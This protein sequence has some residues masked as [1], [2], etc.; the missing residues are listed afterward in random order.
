VDAC[1]VEWDVADLPG[2]TDLPAGV[3]TGNRRQFAMFAVSPGEVAGNTRGVGLFSQVLLQA[4]KEETSGAWPPA[5]G[6]IISRV[7]KLLSVLRNAGRAYQ[8]PVYLWHRDAAGNEESEPNKKTGAH[9]PEGLYQRLLRDFIPLAERTQRERLR[10]GAIW[11]RLAVVPTAVAALCVIICLA[12]T[13]ASG[14]ALVFITGVMVI[15][16]LMLAAMWRRIECY[17]RLDAVI[18]AIRLRDL[19]TLQDIIPSLTCYGPLL[20]VLINATSAY[21]ED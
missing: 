3:P 15:G 7:S 14:A 12:V 21:E 8:T 17:H 9:L 18:V 1:A 2:P 19:S 4:L 13:A 20:T 11:I 5:E 10:W 6:A 16:L